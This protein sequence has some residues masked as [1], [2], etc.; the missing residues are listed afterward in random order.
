MS[1]LTEKARLEAE[2][3]E[4]DEHAGDDD[5]A[6]VTPPDGDDAAGDDAAGDDELEPGAGD[7]EREPGEP[8]D[9]DGPGSEAFEQG[10]EAEQARHELAIATLFGPLFADL[11]VCEQCGGI[12]HKPIASPRTNER[13]KQCDTCNGF[14]AVL[15]GSRAEQH[16]TAQ[17]PRCGGRGYLERTAAAPVQQPPA[18]GAEQPVEEWGTPS[19]MGDPSI[20]PS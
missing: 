18:D 6:T 13:F 17:C 10:L 9:G 11:E 14:G 8:D 5:G 1:T 4:A 19:W 2:R 15:T 7:D 12:G 16:V 20:A 3:A